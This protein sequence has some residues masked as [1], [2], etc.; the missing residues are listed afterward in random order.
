MC[1]WALHVGMILPASHRCVVEAWHGAAGTPTRPPLRVRGGGA[2]KIVQFSDL[3]LDS[4]GDNCNA[5]AVCA[6]KTQE[7]T[8]STALYRFQPCISSIVWFPTRCA[9]LP[10]LLRGEINVLQHLA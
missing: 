5:S 2:F 8:P 4:V 10:R 3:H 7:V 9:R 6:A 1:M